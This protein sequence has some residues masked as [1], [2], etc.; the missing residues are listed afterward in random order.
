M[1]ET[2]TRTILR[3]DNLHCS[4]CEDSIRQIIT[5]V[6]TTSSVTDV[7]VAIAEYLVSFTHPISFNLKTLIKNLDASGFD[8]QVHSSATAYS[9]PGPSRWMHYLRKTLRVRSSEL[10]DHEASHKEMCEAC[11]SEKG[12][13][14]AGPVH[15]ADIKHT[16]F[17]LEGMTCSTCTICS[18]GDDMQ[19]SLIPSSALVLHNNNILDANGIKQLIEDAGYGAE[20]IEST[21]AVKSPAANAPELY[22]VIFSIEGMTCSSCSAAVIRAMESVLS[23]SSP[24]VDLIGNSGSIVVTSRWRGNCKNQDRR[25]RIRMH[26]RRNPPASCNQACDSIG[27]NRYHQ[28]RRSE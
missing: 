4:S 17:V 20:L 2:P 21:P 27:K 10:S 1:S 28:D 5:V 25:W 11:R 22:K 6:D 26:C 9:K 8:V 18:G 19:V 15:K 12:I 13:E 16:R 14:A 7:D 23:I 3:V 24:S